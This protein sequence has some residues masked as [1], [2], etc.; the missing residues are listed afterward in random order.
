MMMGASVGPNLYG[1]GRSQKTIKKC[2]E[3]P[4]IVLDLRNNGIKS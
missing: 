4:E 3:C 1:G 2:S